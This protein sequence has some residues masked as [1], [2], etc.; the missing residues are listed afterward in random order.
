ME[1]SRKTQEMLETMRAEAK[2]TAEILNESLRLL[3]DAVARLP[4]AA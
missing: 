4:S 2:Q 3:R 1:Q